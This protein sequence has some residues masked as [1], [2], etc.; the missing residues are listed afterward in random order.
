MWLNKACREGNNADLTLNR[1]QHDEITQPMAGPIT[2][3][4]GSTTNFAHFLR[5]L[6]KTSFIG[7]WLPEPM[8]AIKRFFNRHLI[9]NEEWVVFSCGGSAAESTHTCLAKHEIFCQQSEKSSFLRPG[10][11]HT[12]CQVREK[13]KMEKVIFDAKPWSWSGFFTRSSSG[14]RGRLPR[15]TQPPKYWWKKSRILSGHCFLSK[16]NKISKAGLSYGQN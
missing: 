5:L 7:R 13:I 16:P 3:P 1:K 2:A 4:E 15:L 11:H 9:N 8:F 10:A 12:T 6:I 14:D